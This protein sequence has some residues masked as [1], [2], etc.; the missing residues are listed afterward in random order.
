VRPLA[1]TID[2]STLF[3][4]IRDGDDNDTARDVVIVD[5]DQVV[6]DVARLIARRLGVSIATP[7]GVP[8]V[9]PLA[10]PDTGGDR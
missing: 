2:V 4:V 7:R 8:T 6:R 1:H 9:V 10:K 5:D 3:L